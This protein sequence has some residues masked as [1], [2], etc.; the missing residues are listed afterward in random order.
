M[1]PKQLDR[2]SRSLGHEARS[3]TSHGL[4]AILGCCS[5]PT[6]G[7]PGGSEKQWVISAQTC[8]AS[9]SRSS[10]S[11]QEASRSSAVAAITEV[12]PT[13]PHRDSW[14]SSAV[15]AIT[16]VVCPTP[17]RRDSWPTGSS[18]SPGP[19]SAPPRTHLRA[20]ATAAASTAV[21]EASFGRSQKS[22][23]SVNQRKART[24]SCVGVPSLRQ[25]QMC[26]NIS[27]VSHMR[28]TDRNATSSWSVNQGS[29]SSATRRHMGMT[30]YKSRWQAGGLRN[31]L[32]SDMSMIMI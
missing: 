30:D 27:W 29:N 32:L 3:N 8:S 24:R 23:N 10:P 28:P 18:G 12:C 13:S 19:E 31:K 5:P 25:Q 16:E 4:S 21:P 7:G 22:V 9:F 14:R 20:Q 26:H 17:A 1:K 11:R 6:L 2:R 15:A